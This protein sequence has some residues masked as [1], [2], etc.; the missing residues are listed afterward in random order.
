[1]RATNLCYRSPKEPNLPFYESIELDKSRITPKRFERESR[2]TNG[3][4][5]DLPQKATMPQVGPG[6]YRAKPGGKPS[7][8]KYR[9]YFIETDTLHR[10]SQFEIIDGSRVLQVAN[11]PKV[12]QG[13]L[14]PW[15]DLNRV[16]LSYRVSIQGGSQLTASRNEAEK[17][18]TVTHSPRRDVPTARSIDAINLKNAKRLAKCSIEPSERKVRNSQ[19]YETTYKPARAMV[20]AEQVF[21]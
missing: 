5:Y 9:P 20:T 16:K 6:S 14:E 4:I 12:E 21:D 2:F 11:L 15:T 8:V 18:A 10:E 3:S 13:V 7:A 19:I 1:M 17:F